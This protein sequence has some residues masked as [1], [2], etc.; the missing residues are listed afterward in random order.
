MVNPGRETLTQNQLELLLKL[1]VIDYDLGELE[2]SKEYLPDMMEN[3]NREM[4]ESESKYQTTAKDLETARVTLN[5]LE[6]DIKTR[7]AELQRFQQQMMSIKTNK[8]YDALVSEIDS[9]KEFISTKETELLETI[10]LVSVLEKNIVEYQ[11]KLEQVKENNT[12]QLEILQQKIDSIGDKT[13]EKTDERKQIAVSIP[14]STMSVYERIRKGKGG[15]AVVA[16]K[17]RACGACYKNLTHKKI[18]D[19]R[20]GDKILTCDNC[21]R[22]LYWNESE[23]R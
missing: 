6:V 19:I 2:R 10:E 15:A 7:E 23:S 11:E 9:V 12:R 14:R 1:Q 4:Q 3:L 5:T 17:S 22:V 8:E 18:Q 16:V 13:E 21:G 20:K